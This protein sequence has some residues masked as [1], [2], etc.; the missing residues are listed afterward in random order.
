MAKSTQTDLEK[1][2]AHIH[3]LPTEVGST[4]QYL[5][6]VLLSINDEIA[7]HIKWNSPAFY[8]SGSILSSK[9][10]KLYDS[11]LTDQ[12]FIRVHRSHL[13]NKKYIARNDKDDVLVLTNGHSVPLSRNKRNPFKESMKRD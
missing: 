1:V 12:G 10:L 7:E 5:R 8:F 6:E 3:N 11:I 13:I 2:S 9:T 4:V